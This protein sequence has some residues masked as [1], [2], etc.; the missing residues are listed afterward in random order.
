MFFYYGIIFS[1]KK[2]YMLWYTCILETENNPVIHCWPLTLYLPF[3]T[4]LRTNSCRPC[5]P[6]Y[7][8]ETILV[9]KYK[10]QLAYSLGYLFMFLKCKWEHKKSKKTYFYICTWKILSCIYYIDFMLVSLINWPRSVDIFTC[11]EFF[12]CFITES[13]TTQTYE[14]TQL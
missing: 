5:Y 14:S 4:V 10:C 12:H 6:W 8:T 2:L 9:A 7:I 11:Q 1:N 3:H 13:Q